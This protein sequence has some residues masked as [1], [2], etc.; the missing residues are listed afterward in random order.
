MSD[1][2][3]TFTVSEKSDGTFN[4]LL[5][6]FNPTWDEIVA[7]VSDDLWQPGPI[8]ETD[9]AEYIANAK[10]YN[11]DVTI[12]GTKS[13]YLVNFT[14]MLVTQ[15]ESLKVIG[16]VDD[17]FVTS[18]KENPE[19][20]GTAG[21]GFQT[22]TFGAN[23]MFAAIS[24]EAMSI[25]NGL[26]V[27]DTIDIT[28]NFSDNKK[29]EPEA[30]P[31]IERSLDKIVDKMEGNA[32]DSF[33]EAVPSVERSLYKIAD[34]LEIDSGEE[35]EE[36]GGTSFYSID[37]DRFSIFGNH[38]HQPYRNS[39]YDNADGSTKDFDTLVNTVKTNPFSIR[40]FMGNNISLTDSNYGTTTWDLVCDYA[41][42]H[43]SKGDVI[44]HI[45]PS[46]II[47]PSSD[48][49]YSAYIVSGKLSVDN[50]LGRNYSGLN[51]YAEKKDTK[52]LVYVSGIDI[53]DPAN[54]TE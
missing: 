10:Y 34:L 41:Y 18:A 35:E 25:I 20:I 3:F 14:D 16:I 52:E 19:A 7:Q 31:S 43:Y 27:G 30:Y 13:S 38:S 11:A 53:Y 44:L 5:G 51:V 28:V 12:A 48:S 24:T 37:F 9:Q 17:E 6:S 33:K 40:D 26:A 15:T 46:F 49:R 47:A 36:S 1:L 39:V 45:A 32:V 4:G 42:I 22:S 2:K 23:G 8:D 29:K 54:R 50:N 21:I